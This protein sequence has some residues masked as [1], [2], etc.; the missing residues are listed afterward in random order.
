MF[1]AE[2]CATCMVLPSLKALVSVFGGM[3]SY[4][5]SLTKLKG[6]S[7]C[8]WRNGELRV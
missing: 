2:W 6:A 1:L 5:C 4:L 8:F 3:V 7:T